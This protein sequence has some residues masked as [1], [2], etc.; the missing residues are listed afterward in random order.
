MRSVKPCSGVE[1]GTKMWNKMKKNLPYPL[2]LLFYFN[3]SV[4]WLSGQRHLTPSLILELDSL[5][6]GYKET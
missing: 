6:N 5:D 2:I 4:N 3:G 1:N